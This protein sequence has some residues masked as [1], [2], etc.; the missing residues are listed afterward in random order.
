[1]DN[2]KLIITQLRFVN[3]LYV[4]FSLKNALEYIYFRAKLKSYGM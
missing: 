1:V 3:K 4:Q 2:V